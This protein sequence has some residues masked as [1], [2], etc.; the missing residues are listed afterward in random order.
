MNEYVKFKIK[1]R[2]AEAVIKS[3]RMFEAKMYAAGYGHG[4]L[5]K[6]FF[7]DFE[8]YVKKDDTTDEGTH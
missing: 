5:L 1:R 4:I 2:T 7:D 8:K 3:Y 6:K